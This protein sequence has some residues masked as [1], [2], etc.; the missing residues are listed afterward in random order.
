MAVGA[1]LESPCSKKNEAARK[2][3]TNQAVLVLE[4]LERRWGFLDPMPG[5]RG[6]GGD[7]FLE[8]R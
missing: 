6:G 7:A 5:L 4:K 8:S 2:K 1:V 3:T